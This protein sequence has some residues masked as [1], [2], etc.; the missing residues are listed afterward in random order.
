METVNRTH[1]EHIVY[2]LLMQAA[3]GLL[4]GNWWAGA[5]LAIG[6]FVAREHAQ[7]EYQ[8]GGP[9][10]LWPWQGFIGWRNDA[11]LDAVCPAVAVVIV[12]LIA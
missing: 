7:R 3:V 9:V 10:G 5:A 1:I 11:V 6:F 12:A 4:S 2:A 8:L